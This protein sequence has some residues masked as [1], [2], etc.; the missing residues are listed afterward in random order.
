[1]KSAVGFLKTSEY[2]A[3]VM[4]VQSLEQLD[5]D[6]LETENER[7]CFLVNLTNLMILHCNLAHIQHR[8]EVPL[9]NAIFAH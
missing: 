9:S 2:Q 7:I 8:L 6:L 3:T 1:M 4:A 5:L